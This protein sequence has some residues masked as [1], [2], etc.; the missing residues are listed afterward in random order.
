MLP[1]SP[2]STSLIVKVIPRAKQ[3]EFVGIMDDGALKIRLRAVPEDGKAN[4]EL[5]SFLERETGKKWEIVSGFTNSRKGVKR[6]D[7]VND[8]SM[9]LTIT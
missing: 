8:K 9:K 7:T 4:E 6:Q 3:T 2:D 5:L 1:I